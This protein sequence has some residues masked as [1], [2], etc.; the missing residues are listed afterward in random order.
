MNFLNL[1]YVVLAYGDP[2]L[3]NAHQRNENSRPFYRLFTDETG[4]TST[5]VSNT[6]HF[7]EQ[8]ANMNCLDNPCHEPA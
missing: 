8:T 5:G 7:L 6:S 2:I 1:F 4:L 3:P